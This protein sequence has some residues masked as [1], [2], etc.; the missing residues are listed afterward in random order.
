MWWSDVR[1]RGPIGI[2]GETSCR[3]G[4]LEVEH[5]SEPEV[6]ASRDEDSDGFAIE[7]PKRYLQ[8]PRGSSVHPLRVVE[9]EHP[10]P[11]LTQ[12]A[13]CVEQPQADGQRIGD[14]V[15]GIDETQRNLES[16]APRRQRARRDLIEDR[17][18]ELRQGGERQRR[19]GLHRTTY[20]NT[21]KLRPGGLE[22]CLPEHRLADPRFAGENEGA[23]AGA[24]H[25]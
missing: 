21:A 12:R 15:A 23:R 24:R 9:P 11:L 3:E 17:G 13:Q 8:G 22:S 20:E 2:L 19:L 1:L 4:V 25:R 10:R 18:D 7:P 5:R 6:V 16:P 14:H